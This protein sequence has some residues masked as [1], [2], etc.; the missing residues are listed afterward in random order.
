MFYNTLNAIY[1]P[2]V[3]NYGFIIIYFDIVYK[4]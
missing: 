2:S 1:A 4:N 3:Y